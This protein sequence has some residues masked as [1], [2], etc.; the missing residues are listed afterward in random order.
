MTWRECWSGWS[1]RCGP[2]DASANARAEEEPDGERRT[3]RNERIRP[4][5]VGHRD[6]RVVEGLACLVGILA[7]VIGQVRGGV[8]DFVHHASRGPLGLSGQLLDTPA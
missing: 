7:I 5:I 6:R 8:A 3:Q 2:P 1:H 4:H